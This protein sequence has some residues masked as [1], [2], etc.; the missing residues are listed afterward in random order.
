MS[1]NKQTDSDQLSE[2]LEDYLEIILSLS[3]QQKVVRVRDIAKHKSVR[4]PTVTAALR[5]LADKRLVEYAARE[6]VELTE[7]GNAIARRVAGRHHFLARFLEQTLGV[8][9]DIAEVDACGLEHHLSAPTLSRLSAFVEYIDTCPGVESQFLDRFKNCFLSP[10]HL[11]DTCD[12][13]DCP[14]PGGGNSG[15]GS[16]IKTASAP[17]V[18]V[19]QMPD[20]LDGEIVRLRIGEE[21]REELIRNGLL[22]GIT[23]RRLRPASPEDGIIIL[24]QGQEMRLT[25]DEASAVYVRPIPAGEA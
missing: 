17:T 4:M 6:Y 9:S 20:G 23:I 15:S 5:R 1:I 25:A 22:P 19:N 7:E 16:S 12:Q 18:A 24:I 8:P 21:V 11:D 10:S 14:A 2:T 13:S 3:L